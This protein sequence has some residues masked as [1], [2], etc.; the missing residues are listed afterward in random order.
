MKVFFRNIFVI[1]LVAICVGQMRAQTP[2]SWEGIPPETMT[3]EGKLTKLLA[4]IS[5]GDLTVVTKRAANGKDMVVTTDAVSRGTLLKLFR[6]SFDEHY[7][8]TIDPLF[9]SLKTVKHD[10]QKDRVR[11]SE[12]IFDYGQHRVTYVETDPKSP[13]QPPRTIASEIGDSMLD[14]IAGIFY[15]RSIPLKVGEKLDVQVSD[16]GLVYK[17]TV[18]VTGREVQ[19][20]ILGNVMCWKVEPEIFGVA[21]L[22]DQKGKMT[23]WFTDDKRRVPVRTSIQTQF[24][25]VEV[26]LKTIDPAK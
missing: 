21:R 6:F 16:S 5:I 3:F 14:M 15:L 4:T 26:K 10:V 9:R 8:S 12:A 20:S 24:G 11:D 1:C 23:M 18:S 17:V 25:R 19:K 7:E 13:N 22:I 2:P